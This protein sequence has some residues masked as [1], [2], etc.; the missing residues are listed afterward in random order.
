[1]CKVSFWSQSRNM[2]LGKAVFQVISSIHGS[3]CLALPTIRYGFVERPKEV[4]EGPTKNNSPESWVLVQGFN[5][6]YHK[7]EALIYYRSLLW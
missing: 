3:E 4:C 2:K 1:M 6:R 7:K 5:F